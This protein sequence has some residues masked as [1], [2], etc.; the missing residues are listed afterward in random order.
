MHDG[1]LAA[2]QVIHSCRNYATLR[3][4]LARAGL[5]CKR[6]ETRSWPN[7]TT[8][9]QHNQNSCRDSCHLMGAWTQLG[10]D[11]ADSSSMGQRVEGAP[12]SGNIKRDADAFLVIKFQ[13]WRSRG[14][15]PANHKQQACQ[16]LCALFECPDD[17]ALQR[18]PQPDL[19][20]QE[21]N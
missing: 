4:V 3:E 1:G 18:F 19:T 5:I 17:V 9:H 20:T 10:A 6:V 15:R 8:T 13:C 21:P 16:R 2:V 14:S 7:D 12:T 11:V